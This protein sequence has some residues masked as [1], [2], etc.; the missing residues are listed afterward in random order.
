M[1]DKK[2]ELLPFAP[3]STKA[4]EDWINEEARRG[5]QVAGAVP[6]VPILIKFSRGDG[7]PYHILM[8]APDEKD[9]VC[10]LP[11]CGFVSRGELNEFDVSAF[12][13]NTSLIKLS[14]RGLVLA[15]AEIIALMLFLSY[16]NSIE[17]FDWLSIQGII[18]LIYFFSILYSLVYSMYAWF[19]GS[20]CYQYESHSIW[21]TVAY[22]VTFYLSI[23]TLIVL[24]P[25]IFSEDAINGFKAVL[26]NR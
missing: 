4:I 15:V 12:D 7:G 14:L 1:K 10:V 6:F 26:Q 2:I 18:G 25:Y 21:P 22:Y 24:L 16:V 5:W 13:Q 8:D 19:L 11:G 23:I 3:Y 9:S 20:S 17:D